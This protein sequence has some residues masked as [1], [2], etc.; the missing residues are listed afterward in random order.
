MAEV[1][2]LK[3]VE[4]GEGHR[5]EADTLLDAAKAV[6]FERMVIIG[7]LDDGDLYVAG[8]ANAGESLILLKQAEHFVVFGKDAVE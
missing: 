4:I 7:R 1:V 3:L 8:T 5:L 2:K 6:A